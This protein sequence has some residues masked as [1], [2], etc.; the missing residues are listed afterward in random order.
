MF[1]EIIEWFKT[2][3]GY[4]SSSDL[5]NLRKDLDFPELHEQKFLSKKL[6]KKRD[7]RIIKAVF[8]QISSKDSFLFSLCG[9][10]LSSRVFRDIVNKSF[11]IAIDKTYAHLES[12]RKISLMLI[13]KSTFENEDKILQSISEPLRMVSRIRLAEGF[14]ESEEWDKFFSYTRMHY[15]YAKEIVEK[16]IQPHDFCS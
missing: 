4:V 16:L 5:K 14:K 3:L 13:I 1:S 11:L 15:P 10:F 6:I 8:K 7:E 9:L 12:F 2:I